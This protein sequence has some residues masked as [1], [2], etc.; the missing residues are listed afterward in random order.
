MCRIEKY[1]GYIFPVFPY[2]FTLLER[3]IIFVQIGLIATTL[4]LRVTTFP[5]I[6]VMTRYTIPLM[7]ACATVDSITS[8]SSVFHPVASVTVITVSVAHACTAKSVI[9]VL[10][11]HHNL[12][13]AQVLL[14][15]SVLNHH[16]SALIT[17]LSLSSISAVT[18]LGIGSASV[19]A[20]YV[21]LDHTTISPLAVI[22][23]LTD[24]ECLSVPFTIIPVEV[25]SHQFTVPSRVTICVV[26]ITT[27]S[28]TVGKIAFPHGLVRGLT[29]L[30]VQERMEV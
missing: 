9:L 4:E 30:V 3:F 5:A 16:L 26:A 8:L 21:P 7:L 19:P 13:H 22:L 23:V 24:R 28:P 1:E 29:S 2:T 27:L 17:A 15:V 14:I 25:S 18:V 12:T 10:V 20:S 6:P 11:A